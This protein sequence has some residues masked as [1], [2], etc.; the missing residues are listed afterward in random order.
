M[1]RSYL[2]DSRPP[3]F[4]CEKRLLELG[5]DPN[6]IAVYCVLAWHADSHRRCF[7]S[8]RRIANILHIG[9]TTVN[10]ALGRL[11]EVGAI[12][13]TRRK[14]HHG[15]NDSNE[16]ELRLLT[17]VGCSAT[18]TPV[19]PQ[20]HGVP[21]QEHGCSATGTELDSIEQDLPKR[22]AQAPM[23]EPLL[24]HFAAG[25]RQRNGHSCSLKE[26]QKREWERL[27][28]MHLEPLLRAKID[29]W[30]DHPL[31]P[32]FRGNR[33]FGAFLQWF[34]DIPVNGTAPA[35][36]GISRTAE[37]WAAEMHSGSSAGRQHYH[38]LTDGISDP[39]AK[40]QTLR[41]YGGIHDDD[42]ID[43]IIA[44]CDDAR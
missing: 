34:D 10:R 30:W 7:P 1:T 26:R 43:A 40:R 13:L 6:A 25:F 8:Q 32:T 17:P 2:K 33:T 9:H 44:A 19:P 28:G 12:G 41:L 23:S 42:V 11:V 27:R 21:V 38:E 14:S 35:A 16:Y 39:A 3:F 20:E 37:Q 4:W 24:E 15:D 36:P 5:L 29:A 31:P 18:G 22:G